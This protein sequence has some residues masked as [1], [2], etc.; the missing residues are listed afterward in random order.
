MKESMDL[1]WQVCSRARLSRDARFDGKFFIAVLT[2]RVYCRSICPAPTAQEKNVRYYSSAAAA[3]EAG[4]R[5]CLRCRPECSPGTPAWLGTPSTVSRALRLIADGGL[6]D[7]GVELLAERLGVG[8]RH[9]RRLFLQHLGATPSAVAQTRRMH[10]AKKLIDETSLPMSEVALASGFGCVRRFNAAIRKVYHRTPT[11]IRHLSRQTVIPAQNEYF[12]RLRFRPPYNWDGMLRFLAPR[13]IPGVEEVHSGC[14]RR[15]ISLN[16]IPGWLEVSLDGENDGLAVRVQFSD[17]RALYTIIERVRAMFDLNADWAAIAQGLS[18]DPVLA[19]RTAANPGLRVPGCW[20]GFEL[21]VRAILGQQITVKGATTLSGLL[22][23]TLGQPIS[24]PGGL[25]YLFPAPEVLADSKLTGLGLTN[26]RSETI[27]LLARA[28]SDGRIAFDGAA[29][30]DEFMRRMCEIPGIGKWTAQYVAMRALGEP[31]AFPSGDLGLLRA[32]SLT[33]PRDLEQRAE[34]WRPWRAY[35][36]MYLWSAA[37]VPVARAL[38]CR[39]D[40]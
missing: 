16:K 19:A 10:F 38:A 3:A 28:V 40:S 7:G 30:S 32:L 1:D 29:G 6:A 21:A 24:G 12:F 27:R 14:Y 11:Q 20:N 31:D 37:T 33:S 9:L 23:R 35:A 36:S 15:T 39:R 8:S 22:A 17:P 34:T 18:A 4:F 5:P 13:A 25:T 2:S 26:A